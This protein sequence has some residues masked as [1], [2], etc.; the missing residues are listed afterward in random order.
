MK[1]NL[2]VTYAAYADVLTIEGV[3]YTGELFRK[4]GFCAEG[5]IFK[6][7]KREDGVLTFKQ[8]KVQE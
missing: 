3:K 5:S 4:L 7:I 6:V 1:H 2:H 8:L